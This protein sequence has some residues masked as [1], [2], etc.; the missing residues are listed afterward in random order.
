MSI[1]RRLSSLVPG[2]EGK[3]FDSNVSDEARLANLGY[4]QE[5]KRSFSL[6]G[7]IGFSCKSEAP[8]SCYSYANLVLVSIVTCWTALGGTLI[9]G[10]LSGGPPVMVW[11]W[12]G[13]CVLTLCVGYSFA[14]MCSAYPIASGQYGWVAVLAPPKIARSMSYVTGWFMCTGIVAMGAVNNVISLYHFTSRSTDTD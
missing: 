9:I 1:S 12:L 5:L 2:K 13:I 3:V 11:S 10:I 7:M 6:I 8:L 14:E 4:E